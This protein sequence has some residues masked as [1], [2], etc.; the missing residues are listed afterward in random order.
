MSVGSYAV[1]AELFPVQKALFLKQW[2]EIDVTRFVT[3]MNKDD[4]LVTNRSDKVTQLQSLETLSHLLRNLRQ[5]IGFGESRCDAL[6][7]CTCLTATILAVN[8]MAF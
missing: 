6:R 4:I 8:M 7:L 2:G 3:R 1:D 5:V